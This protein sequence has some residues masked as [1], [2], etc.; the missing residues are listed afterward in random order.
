MVNELD[1]QNKIA[2]PLDEDNER[3]D[4]A[5]KKLHL[6]RLMH[7]FAH[8]EFHRLRKDISMD[9]GC[10]LR[11]AF[12]NSLLSFHTQTARVTSNHNG[13]VSV[14]QTQKRR[15]I[16]EGAPGLSRSKPNHAHSRDL[17]RFRRTDARH[18]LA[19]TADH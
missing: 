5:D 14:L 19:Q 18:A 7:S 6:A 4:F 11:T 2:I 3:F 1:A 9:D 16:D 17:F 10:N 8:G 15:C 13:L 12:A